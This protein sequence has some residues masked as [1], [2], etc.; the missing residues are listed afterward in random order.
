M[1]DYR[2]P[3]LDIETRLND[4]LDR[5]TLEEMIMQ[6]DQFSSHDFIGHDR[7]AEVSEEKL[8]R[9]LRGRSCGTIQLHGTTPR[10]ANALQAYAVE[11]TRLGIPFLFCQEALHG[12]GNAEATSFPQQIGLAAT[13]D[14]ELGYA[15]GRA[16]ATEARAMGIHETWNPVM[17]L[18]RDPRFGRTEEGFGEDTYL[19]AQFAR[20]TVKGLQGER[21]TDPDAVASEPKHYAAYGVPVGG[22]NCAPCAIS[23]HEIFTDALPIFEAAVAEAGAVNVMCSY[24]ALD[25]RPVA[26][27]RELL[28]DVLRGQW[29]MRGFVRSDMTAV[30]RLYDNHYTASSRP[31][32]M[33]QGME[34]GVDLQLYD[35]GH[36]EWVEGLT[37]QV[38]SGRLDKAVVRQAA[39]RVLRVKF[40]L[41]LFENPYVDESRY[42]KYVHAPAHRDL[43][44]RIAR[45]SVT[46]LKNQ[47]G[48]LPLS[49]NIGSIAVLGPS[50]GHAMLGDYTPFGKDG[51]SILDGVKAAVSPETRVSYDPGCNILGDAAI[52]FGPD[53]LTDEQGNPGLTGRYYN[54]RTFEG[55]PVVTHTDRMIRFNWIMS[56]P[57]P[58][59]DA[60]C[61]SVVWTGKLTPT[62]TFDGYIG[63]NTQDSMRLYVDGALIL[64]GWGERLSANRTVPFRFEAG[65]SYDLR[66]EFTNDQRG[67]RIV[68]GYVRQRE[69]FDRAIELAKNADVALVC[70]GDSPDTSGE[71]F[72][73]ATLDLPGNQQ[74]FVEAIAATGTPVVLLMLSGR[75]ASVVWAHEHVPAIVEAWFPGEEG[76]H[77]VCDVLFGD[78]APAG[79]LPISFPQTVGQIPCH[80]ARR[81]GGGMRYI[82][83][84]WL[85]LYPFGFGLSYTTFDMGGLTLAE[86]EIAP[87]QTVTASVTVTNTGDRAGT[88]VPQLYI[89]DLFASTV[90]PR[91]ALCAFARVELEP[92]ESKVVKMEIG[93]KSMRTLGPDYVWR[94]EPGDFEVIL[95]SDAEHPIMTRGFRMTEG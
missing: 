81:P 84:S 77:G 39:G 41:G 75:P 20:E 72:D 60:Y 62:D 70:V 36:D 80:Y 93:P 73:R 59:L 31:E 94:L 13:F 92:G 95:A 4:L 21:L 64:D 63:F 19:G 56:K 88:A 67:A 17:D 12:V 8:D 54:G 48:L 30:A 35:F 5:M 22:I 15:M 6:T 43:A 66:V 53:V 46:L 34:A 71:N 37:A 40:M 90:K 9:L 42:E 78:Y 89:R 3:G 45:E 83:M 2:N 87:G 24:A 85:P 26:S 68:F 18:M 16:I 23:R 49:K 82:D 33:A 32:A 69:C 57:Y 27:D 25:G 44:R 28:T 51:V 55:E 52:P 86:S 79:R 76:G 61:F 10:Q 7:S 29:G 47:D 14:P 65:R 1:E 11:K 58:D 74:A 50:A 38:A 91:M